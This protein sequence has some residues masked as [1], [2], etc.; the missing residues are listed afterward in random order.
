MVR[1]MLIVGVALAALVASPAAAQ[2]DFEVSPTVVLAGGVVSVSGRDCPPLSP[3][4]VK[5][6]QRSTGTII[7]QASDTTDAEGSFSFEIKLPANLA[8]GF[9]DLEARCP[10]KPGLPAD[11]NRRALQGEIEGDYLV[12]REVIEIRAPG[13]GDNGGGGGVDDGDLVRTGS[14]LNGLGLIGAGLLTVGGLVLI[15]SKRRNAASA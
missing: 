8:P 7:Y 2:Y 9:Y 11:Y 4:G 5:V 15:A 10:L 6:T 3:V 13:G 14:D 12:F 1:K